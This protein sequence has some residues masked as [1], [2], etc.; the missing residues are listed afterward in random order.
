[1]TVRQLLAGLAGTTTVLGLLGG[2][3]VAAGG[4]APTAVGWWTR[5]PGASEAPDDGFE[6]AALG[7]EPAS[8][9]ALRFD[10]AGS[11]PVATLTLVE[12]GGTVTPATALQV[13]TTSEPWEPA[14]PG[15]YGDAPA[16]D[17]AA[18]ADL[19]RDEE[20]GE[21]TA[22]VGSLLAAGSLM[23][24]PAETPG[25]GSPLDPG[26]RVTFSAAALAVVATPDASS[27]PAFA[28][29]SGGGATFSPPPATSASPS[30]TF[31][32][33]GFDVT[34]APAE[35]PDA[36]STPTTVAV[37]NTDDDAGAAEEEAFGVPELAAGATPPG[38]GKPWARL[39]VLVPLSAVVGIASV[40]GRKV[41]TRRGVVET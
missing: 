28:Q 36:G 33:G 17:C 18:A 41:L 34:P 9:A 12:S 15:A 19:A 24:V 3:A 1:M 23:V 25:G 32:G 26:F 11:S 13:C 10:V 8:V 21:W 4:D 35:V 27:S 7:G 20:A 31:G 29:P 16:P 5:A 37:D 6:V 38:G 40:R 30:G 14:D 22:E 39:V 2:V